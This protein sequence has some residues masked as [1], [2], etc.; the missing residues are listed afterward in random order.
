MIR[1]HLLVVPVVLLGAGLA[2]AQN[3]GAPSALESRSLFNDTAV[4]HLSALSSDGFEAKPS[5]SDDLLT[6]YFA[7]S[8]APNF[9]ELD[10]FVTTRAAVGQ[11]FGPPTN[12]AELNGSARDHTPT[13]NTDQTYMIFSS[14]R[15][16]GLGSDDAWESSRADVNSAWGAPVNLPALSSSERDM[17]YTMTPDGLCLYFSSNRGKPQGSLDPDFDLYVSTRASTADA[18]PAPTPVAE[19]NT[20]PFADKFPTVTGDN[21]A[22][23]FASD[24]PG[25]VLGDDLL[26]S[27]DTWVA[28]RPDTNSAWT[29]VENVFENNTKHNE[30]LMSVA[31]DHSEMFFVANRPDTLGGFDLYRVPA[32][33]GVKRYGTGTDGVFGTPRLRIVGGDPVPGNPALGLEVSQA[34]PGTLGMFL[35]GSELDTGPLLV[36]L[37]PG[38]WSRGF[39]TTVGSSLTVSTPIPP[40]PNLVGLL[41]HVQA[42]LFD[43]EGAAILPGAPALIVSATPG[44]RAVVQAP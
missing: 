38:T 39:F 33:R 36:G 7:S 28:L 4:E 6:L 42:L 2:A 41:F 43:D 18:W 25:S 12:L 23:Y 30:Y 31:N 11:P 35:V 29:I 8:Q 16:G 21:L 5:I 15:D 3:E 44:V 40:N 1:S 26:P 24:R 32:L 17:G 22:L 34:P 10:L 20:T 19:L 9:G 14:S 37:A 13:T 27:Q